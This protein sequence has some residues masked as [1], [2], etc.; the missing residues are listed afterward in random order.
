[1]KWQKNRIFAVGKTYKTQRNYLYTNKLTLI[2]MKK[3][4][5]TIAIILCAASAAFAQQ[6]P[7]DET[8]DAMEQIRTRCGLD[9][10]R[11]AKATGD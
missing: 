3:A 2:Q 6:K 9:V 7:Y 11:Y 8:I 1:M 10:R 5:I 4:L